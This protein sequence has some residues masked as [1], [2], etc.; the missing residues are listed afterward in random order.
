MPPASYS[1][2]TQTTSHQTHT[3]R[4]HRLRRHFSWIV[5]VVWS[6]SKSLLRKLPFLLQNPERKPRFVWYCLIMLSRKRIT[7]EMLDQNEQQ[8]GHF[9]PKVT[10]VSQTNRE[11]NIRHQKGSPFLEGNEHRRH[12]TYLGVYFFFIRRFIMWNRPTSPRRRGPVM[13]NISIKSSSEKSPR[14]AV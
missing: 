1:P 10:T 6:V 7:G 13:E 9:Q 8:R 2:P 11:K 4:M 14:F 5:H 3:N 12:R